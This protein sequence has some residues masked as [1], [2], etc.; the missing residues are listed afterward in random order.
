MVPTWYPRSGEPDTQAD[1]G[2]GGSFTGCHLIPTQALWAPRWGTTRGVWST[3]ARS[4]RALGG[5]VMATTCRSPP[6]VRRGRGPV[7]RPSVAHHHQVVDRRLPAPRPRSQLTIDAVRRSV[8]G[9]STS[10]ASCA[11][12]ESGGGVS[13]AAIRRAM[14]VKRSTSWG[15][16]ARSRTSRSRY[17]SHFLST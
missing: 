6:A 11:Y 3:C 10:T 2:G 16:S 8:V 1:W 15:V 17:D 7:R 12:S 13:I 9:G 5:P 4:P 14:S